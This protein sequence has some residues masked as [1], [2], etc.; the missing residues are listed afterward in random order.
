MV[1][2]PNLIKEPLS[3]ARHLPLRS[4]GIKWTGMGPC[5]ATATGPCGATASGP[6]GVTQSDTI[7][8][9]TAIK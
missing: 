6:C 5:G 2:Q 1:L 9:K 7:T 3:D 8:T 4:H